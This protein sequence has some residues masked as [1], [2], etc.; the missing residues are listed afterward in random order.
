MTLEW[1]Y[2]Q[3]FI[4][5]TLFYFNG[6]CDLGKCFKVIHIWSWSRPLC[7]K[8]MLWVWWL[9]FNLLSRYCVTREFHEWP[10]WPRTML[11]GHPYSNLIYCRPLWCTML[12]VQWLIFNL[13]SSYCVNAENTDRQPA[14]RLA[15]LC[16]KCSDC[17]CQN[18]ARSFL[19][20]YSHFLP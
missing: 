12:W 10:L 14:G 17:Q 8:P 7:F 15:F 3:S 18:Q 1:I 16:K 19:L 4:M 11:Q 20:S 2:A 13:L 5:L 6:L 9:N